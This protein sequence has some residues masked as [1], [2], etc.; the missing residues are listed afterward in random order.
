MNKSVA[1]FSYIIKHTKV[2]FSIFIISF[3]VNAEEY[4]T[5]P[6]YD[7]IVCLRQ[8][9]DEVLCIVTAGVF[10]TKIFNHK[11]DI[12]RVHLM[13]KEAWYTDG[14]DISSFFQV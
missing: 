6:V 10:Y 12:H 1:S 13:F 5:I 9:G 11:V 8:V 3:E 2:Y 7:E 4:F 14:G